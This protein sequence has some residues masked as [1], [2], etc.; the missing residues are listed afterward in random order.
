MVG[1]EIFFKILKVEQ[2]LSSYAAQPSH[3]HTQSYTQTNT[4]I[5]THTHTHN[6]TPEMQLLTQSQVWTM[7]ITD[8]SQ[9]FRSST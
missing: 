5:H 8:K 9:I 2:S 4:Y 7:N 1:S 3:T 6:S